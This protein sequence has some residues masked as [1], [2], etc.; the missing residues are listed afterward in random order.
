MVV[1]DKPSE[2]SCVQIVHVFH[3]QL[4]T[5]VATCT[6]MYT[7]TCMKVES[8]VRRFMEVQKESSPETNPK[9]Y[10]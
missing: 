2:L 1:E 4:H 5:N 7:F 8:K 9:S 10:T 6:C 3:M